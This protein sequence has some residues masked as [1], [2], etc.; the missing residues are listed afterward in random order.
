[1]TWAVKDI[2]QILREHPFFRQLEEPFL[3]LICGCARNVHFNGG[4]YLFHEGDPADRF[5]LI[6]HGAAVLEIRAPG[7]TLAFQT[8]RDGEIAG[9]SWLIPP[10]RWTF[11]ARALTDIRAIGV[12]AACLRAKSEADHDLGYELMKRFNSVLAQRLQAT[13]LQ[14]LDVYGQHA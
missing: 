7:R 5:Y 4:D 1:M 11:D 2:E 13:R 6:R 14:I 3:R 8:L 10:Y 12:D 9:V